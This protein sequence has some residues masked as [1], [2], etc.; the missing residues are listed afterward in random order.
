[1]V[2]VVVGVLW[3]PVIQAYGSGEL[4]VYMQAI[5]AYLSPAVVAVFTSAVAW[6]RINETVRIYACF[7]PIGVWRF[8]GGS[9]VRRKN[10]RGSRLVNIT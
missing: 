5:L 6:Q 8:Q 2:L 3:L 7:L 4:F 1:M 9:R 10:R